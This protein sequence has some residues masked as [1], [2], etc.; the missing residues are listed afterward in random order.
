MSLIT[1][2]HSSALFNSIAGTPILA[3]SATPVACTSASPTVVFTANGADLATD[4]YDLEPKYPLL[5]KLFCTE[6]V[7]TGTVAY[8]N[9]EYIVYITGPAG[10]TCHRLDEKNFGLTLRVEN[11]STAVLNTTV[12]I[13]PLPTLTG[14][15]F[16]CLAGL[17]LDNMNRPEII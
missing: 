16:N 15:T 4:P 9:P 11:W 17:A 12:T 1:V 13:L 14:V 7:M 5:L 2:Y 8:P 6:V 3:N 10:T